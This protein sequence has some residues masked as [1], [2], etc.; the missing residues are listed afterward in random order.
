MRIKNRILPIFSNLIPAALSACDGIL[1]D[2]RTSCPHCHGNL[3]RYDIRTKHFANVIE[4]SCTKTVRVRIQRFICSECSAIVY[5]HQPFYPNTRVGSPVVDL[6]IILSARMPYT[7]TSTYLR[8]IGINVD[9]WSVRN[10]A[11]KNPL[12]IPATEQ[13]G[14]V[15]PVSIISLVALFSN[16]ENTTSIGDAEVLRACGYPSSLKTQGSA[17]TGHE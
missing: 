7:R 4:G 3:V 12:Q 1:F 2:N 14:I 11:I 10:Y 5:A 16:I 9:R 8:Q 13:Y 6:C 15:L 17:R